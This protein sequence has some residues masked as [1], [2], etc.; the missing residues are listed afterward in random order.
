MLL[1][2]DT[3][4]LINLDNVSFFY[5]GNGKIIASMTDNK[6]VTI[7][8]GCTTNDFDRFCNMLDFRRFQK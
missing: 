1:R 4:E 5:L 7:K 3:F 6:Q 8:R 2:T